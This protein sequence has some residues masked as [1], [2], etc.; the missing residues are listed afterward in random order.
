MEKY[1]LTKNYPTCKLEVGDIVEWATNIGL[2]QYYC[3]VKGLGVQGIDVSKYPEYWEKVVEK[4][5]EVLSLVCT[6]NIGSL[7]KGDIV[8][9]KEDKF[10]GVSKDG[11]S[12]CFNTNNYSTDIWDIHS[13]KRL[14]DRTVLSIGDYV[15]GYN[16]VRKP[17]KITGFKQTTNDKGGTDILVTGEGRSAYLIYFNC[18]KVEPI[19]KTEDGVDIFDGDECWEVLDWDFFVHNV[20]SAALIFLK[21]NLHS[22]KAFS[23]KE[24]AEKYV[25]EN[26]QLLPTDN[27]ALKNIFVDLIDK[28]SSLENAEKEYFKHVIKNKI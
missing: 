4:D 6:K 16:S 22:R 17:F 11:I 19:L 3:K 2:P 18:E 25:L 21:K 5:Y 23:T 27:Q 1:R 14:S 8:N 13:V 12:V 28:S 26:K 10:E 7:Y 15:K 9:K 20:S 24:A